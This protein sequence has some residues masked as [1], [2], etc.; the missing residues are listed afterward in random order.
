MT[1][2]DAIRQAGRERFILSPGCTVPSFTPQRT[3]R[4][5][6]EHTRGP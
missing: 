2:A 1:T 5:L 3:L 4:C 6:R